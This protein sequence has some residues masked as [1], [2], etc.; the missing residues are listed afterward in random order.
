FDLCVYQRIVCDRH[1]ACRYGTDVP[2]M[3]NRHLAVRMPVV[4]PLLSPPR[5][6]PHRNPIAVRSDILAVRDCTLLE[7]SR[8]CV[9]HGV[10]PP[11][12]LAPPQLVEAHQ[13]GERPERILQAR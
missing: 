11:G 4:R 5:S 9:T 3:E 10:L 1:T 6:N 13:D 7:E 12:A 8:Q 2:A